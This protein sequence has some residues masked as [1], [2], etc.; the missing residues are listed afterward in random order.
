MSPDERKR[1]WEVTKATAGEELKKVLVNAAMLLMS[2][3]VPKI[4]AISKEVL[5]K[6]I[7][8]LLLILQ[9]LPAVG[10]FLK[11]AGKVV[12]KGAATA[13]SQSIGRGAKATL[14]GARDLTKA[15][16]KAARLAKAGVIERGARGIRYNIKGLFKLKGN[17]I[18]TK[19]ADAAGKLRSVRI[20]YNEHKR[21]RA[22]ST[23]AQHF[24][25]AK[26]SIGQLYEYGRRIAGL[27]SNSKKTEKEEDNF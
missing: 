27:F 25:M 19:V 9:V 16:T 14:K 11:G 4:V 1:V 26:E 18:V 10:K 12:K 21:L 8:A 13:V 22:F 2:N 23:G 7:D 15:T 17:N 24:A 20:A 5:W 6:S 3:I